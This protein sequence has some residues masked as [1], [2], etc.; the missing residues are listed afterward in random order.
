MASRQNLIPN[1]ELFQPSHTH[2]GVECSSLAVSGVPKY[3]QLLSWACKWI[4]KPDILS[5]PGSVLTCILYPKHCKRKQTSVQPCPHQSNAKSTE[6]ADMTEH[7]K[8]TVFLHQCSSLTTTVSHIIAVF[9]LRQ[10]FANKNKKQCFTRLQ[11]FT[12]LSFGFKFVWNKTCKT[13]LVHTCQTKRSFT[14]H[15]SPLLNWRRP[16]TCKA[17][18][19]LKQFHLPRKFLQENHATCRSKQRKKRLSGFGC[20]HATCNKHKHAQ[21]S[22]R[23]ARTAAKMAFASSLLYTPVAVQLTSYIP[24]CFSHSHQPKR[25]VSKLQKPADALQKISTLPIGNPFGACIPVWH[26]NTSASNCKPHC[27]KTRLV[28]SRFHILLFRGSSKDLEFPSNKY[29]ETFSM[30]PFHDLSASDSIVAEKFLSGDPELQ[31]VEACTCTQR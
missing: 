15:T 27:F 22:F 23:P 10:C 19:K 2:A 20:F 9:R 24:A 30:I 7:A 16:E 3:P 5:S 26:K 11:C 28:S 4:L 18:I 17:K 6:H 14:H 21:G 31:G 12:S 8:I 13:S 1:C 25:F 29:L